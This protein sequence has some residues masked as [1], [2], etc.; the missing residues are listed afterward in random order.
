[1]T[2]AFQADPQGDQFYALRT[3]RR[4]GSPVST[5]I[6]LAQAG[7]RWYGYTPARSGKVRRISRDP[8]VQVAPSDFHGKPRGDWRAG[9]A[10][11]L[12]PPQLLAARRALTAKYGV[13]FRLF[14]VVTLLGRARRRGGRAVGLEIT[15][16]DAAVSSLSVVQW[17]SL[18]RPTGSP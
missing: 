8:R 14:V 7:G 10:R 3:F 16:D 6:W 12:R 2:L 18:H 13:K 17:S 11:I 15:F 4:D 1:M 9:R 5:A